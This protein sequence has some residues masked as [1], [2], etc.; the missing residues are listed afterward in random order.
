METTNTTSSSNVCNKKNKNLKKKYI[1]I[2]ELEN[3]LL[4]GRQECNCEATIHNLVCNCLSMY[5]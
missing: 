2:S 1:P 3:A 5:D 4:P